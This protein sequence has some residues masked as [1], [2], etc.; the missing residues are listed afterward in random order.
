[1][2]QGGYCRSLELRLCHGSLGQVIDKQAL[3]IIKRLVD[4]PM[5]N[6][7][8]ARLPAIVGVIFPYYIACFVVIEG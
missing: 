1:M 2:H 7:K 5:L 4:R 8:I 3:T 6:G